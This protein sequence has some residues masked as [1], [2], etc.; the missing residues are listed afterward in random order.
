MV[1]RGNGSHVLKKKL[2]EHMTQ[3][4]TVRFSRRSCEFG[5]C[6]NRQA[7]APKSAQHA[8]MALGPG[9]SEYIYLGNTD[10]SEHHHHPAGHRYWARP[11]RN[12][13]D[14]GKR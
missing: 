11:S 1:G 7:F 2:E 14:D 8:Q 5:A 9:V 4:R 12:E 3:V 13:W 10:R 6:A